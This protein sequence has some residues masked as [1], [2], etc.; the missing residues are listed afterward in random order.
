LRLSVGVFALSG[1]GWIWSYFI[2]RNKDRQRELEDKAHE[3]RGIDRAARE[4][5]EYLEEAVIITS[6]QRMR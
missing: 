2:F 4:K 6:W 1:G 5:E 3:Q